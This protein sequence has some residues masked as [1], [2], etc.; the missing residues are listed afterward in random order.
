MRPEPQGQRGERQIPAVTHPRH[1]DHPDDPD[2]GTRHKIGRPTPT[3]HATRGSTAARIHLAAAH[4]TS[5]SAGGP[6]DTR[7]GP[8]R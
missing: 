1:T 4:A 5:R 3:H 2:P 8:D 6:G 7:R